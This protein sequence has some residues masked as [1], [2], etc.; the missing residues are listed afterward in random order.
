[1]HK[2]LSFNDYMMTRDVILKN[3]S[4]GTIDTCFDDSDVVGS[5]SFDLELGGIYNCMIVLIGDEVEDGVGSG[6]GELVCCK[7]THKITF[8]GKEKVMQVLVGNDIY[9]ILQRK[10]RN[11]NKK[12]FWFEYMR[13]D[14]YQ[15]DDMVKGSC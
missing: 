10:I 5:E 4:T 3:M 1:M 12:I 8:I 15:V 2:V 13:K 11:I 14:L 6:Y 7:T 9:Y